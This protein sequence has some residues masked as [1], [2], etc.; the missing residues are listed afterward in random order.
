M[1]RVLLVDDQ[2]LI[3]Q[4]IKALL[5]LEPD[6][7]IIGEAENGQGAI[8]L[9]ETLKPDVILMDVRMPIMDGVA[10]TR[11]ICQRFPQTKVLV[12][13]TFDDDE[14]VAESLRVGA[15]GYLL[16]DTPSEELAAAIRTVEKGYT[17]LG[18]GLAQKMS[19]KIPAPV[20]TLPNFVPPGFY[21][22]TPREKE[23]LQLIAGGASNQ[24][25]AR[26]LYISVGTVKNH[27]TSILNRLELRDR[28]QA[29][30][31]AINCL[32]ILE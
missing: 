13:T 21:E 15:V 26:S 8:Q 4:G 2:R 1:L 28:T 29:A 23:I 25:I 24:E 17:Q 12:L 6:I 22:L 14:Y 10:A 3:R 7:E 20:S 5:E 16:K 9:V 18:P 27:V 30:I 19:A 32:S 11:E 31:F